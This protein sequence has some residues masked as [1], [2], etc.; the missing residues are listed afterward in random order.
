MRLTGA[1]AANATTGQLTATFANAPQLPFTDIK[2]SF[3]GGAKAL[4]ANPLGCGS[5]TTNT[6]LSPYSGNA[7][8]TPSSAFTVDNN[9]SGG[10]CPATLP[11]AP[12]TTATL[13]SKVAGASTN[14]TLNV[15]RAD[16]E[17]ILSGLT[18]S[19]PEG[20][21]A[22]LNA[23]SKL[24]TE[25][26]AAEAK[27]PVESLIGSASV[28]AGAGTEPLALTGSLY[29][30]TSYK[31]GQLGLAAVVP[32]NAGPYKLGNVIARAAVSLNSATGQVTITTDPLPTIVGGVPLRLRNLKLEITKAGFLV[33]P[34]SCATSAISGS[35]TSTAAQ[36]QPFSSAVHIEG[37]GSLPFAPT[38]HVT[39]STTSFDSPLG[40]TV[41]IGLI[42]GSADLHNVVVTLPEGITLN[43]AVANGLQACTDAQLG[44]GTTNPVECPASSV[45]GNAEFVSPLLPTPLSG[46][47]YIGQPLSSNPESGEEYRVFVAAKD[48]TYGISVRL[49]GALSAN[50]GT[51]R[52]TATFA[53]T[54]P[55]PFTETKLSFSGGEH[56]ALASPEACGTAT[57]ASALQSSTGT[58]ATPTSAYTVDANGAGEGCAPS[59]P[60]TP[61]FAVNPSTLA[62]GAFDPLSLGFESG[63]REQKLGSVAAQLPP[64]LLGEIAAVP[65]CPEP[66]AAQ[67]SCGAESLIG[68]ATV[69]V[70]LGT[71]PLQLS[72]RVY[73]TGPYEGAPFGL[74][75]VVPALAGPYNLGTVVV[76]ARIAVDPNDAHLTITSGAFPT[77][78]AGVPLRLKALALAIE[79]AGFMLNPTSCASGS[80]AA[81]ILSSIGSSQLA[82]SPFQSTGCTGLAFT[83][84]VSGTASAAS[85]RENGASLNL[86]LSYP[87][88]HQANLS[89]VS[90]SLP[91]QL[92]ARVST[93]G[94]ACLES[95]FNANPAACPA[96]AKVGEASVSTPVL[97][98]TMSGP[99][100]LIATGGAAFPKLAVILSGDGVTLNLHGQTAIASGITSATFSGLPDVPIKRFSLTLPQGPSSLLALN[101]TLCGGALAMPTTLFG[102]NSKGIVE[103]TTIAA[104]QCAPAAGSA[105]GS[106]GSGGLSGLEISPS[107]F[108]AAGAGASIANGAT[109]SARRR[110]HAKRHAQIGATVSFSAASAGHVSFVLERKT[111]GEL[112]GR[113]CVAGT[114]K[115]GSHAHARRCVRY[116]KVAVRRALA[117]EM[118]GGH[119][120]ARASA[121]PLGRRCTRTTRVSAFSFRSAAGANSFRFSGRL[122]GRGLLPGA[123]RLVAEASASRA[124][125][126]APFWIVRG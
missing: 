114:A 15:A 32:A 2:L 16:G 17:G 1:V 58:E 87:S 99:V 123:Y 67:G 76:R 89:A 119:C 65:T 27:C 71:S 84:T 90:V 55:I 38:L 12:A 18:M 48:P 52:L 85:E 95:T 107:H 69:I 13:S 94:K 78:L 60:F 111:V 103:S 41:A 109:T 8:A 100:Y 36:T 6:T 122:G 29:L 59:I 115:S 113:R 21:L 40:L 33:N 9:G 101:G 63:D 25:T 110:T 91:S 81:T 45:V 77:M 34:A 80:V 30:T 83:P 39:P 120:A 93:L 72:G 20:M 118:R 28:S 106:G 53:N 112:R 117:G 11:F 104:P 79:R 66:A 125:Q 124:S 44:A 70:G 43:P 75:V 23:V 126:S 96:A 88:E 121:A 54:P 26:Q 62:A 108:A 24:C 46:S 86:E 68:S 56:A 37:C 116:A 7:A 35:L 19:L 47:I 97:P 10:S 49:V 73:L 51:G 14:L 74:S 57:T 4:F 61:T 3:N 82:S 64:G 31:G 22:N 50:V 92:V 102:Q 98:G 5:A 42:S 105:S